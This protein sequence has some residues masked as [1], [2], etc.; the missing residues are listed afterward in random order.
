MHTA[1]TFRQPR[2]LHDAYDLSAGRKSADS[3]QMVFVTALNAQK[4][5]PT[6]KFPIHAG[7]L[8]PKPP[9]SSNCSGR[10]VFGAPKGITIDQ[11]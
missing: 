2:E 11:F 10:L 4:V 5:I 9:D 8:T 6:H 1:F 7:F 3:K